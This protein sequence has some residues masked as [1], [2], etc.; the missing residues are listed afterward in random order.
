M[1]IVKNA[2]IK[3]GAVYGR[4]RVIGGPD[5]L[6]ANLVPFDSRGAMWARRYNG[7]R[8]VECLGRYFNDYSSFM[9]R[10][11]APGGD[12]FIT[13]GPLYVVYSY[14]TPIAWVTG[15]SEIKVPD[16]SYGVTTKH[17]QNMCRTWMG[18]APCGHGDGNMAEC[19]AWVSIGGEWV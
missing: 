14:R 5:G 2:I 16:E 11:Y 13:V 1:D 15:R 3:Q 6:L 10:I 9:E 4:P 12:E 19:S 7:K 18:T 17:H 8:S